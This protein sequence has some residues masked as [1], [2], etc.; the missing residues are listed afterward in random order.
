MQAN[1]KFWNKKLFYKISNKLPNYK[2][3]KVLLLAFYFNIKIKAICTIY[4]CLKNKCLNIPA[5]KYM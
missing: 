3:I 5:N 4:L 2:C 1:L